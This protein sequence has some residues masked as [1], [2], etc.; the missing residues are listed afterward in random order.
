MESAAEEAGVD[1]RPGRTEAS[2]ATAR[3]PD[4]YT[5]VGRLDS[6]A[7]AAGAAGSDDESDDEFPDLEEN[8]PD[9]PEVREDAPLAGIVRPVTTQ[10]G[11]LELAY[12]KEAME[13]I[14]LI[15]DDRPEEMRKL[16]AVIRALNKR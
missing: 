10:N 1:E 9:E 15:A 6:A 5:P 13:E 12:T 3:Q 2:H 8:D 7:G 4:S 11:T 16:H 14:A